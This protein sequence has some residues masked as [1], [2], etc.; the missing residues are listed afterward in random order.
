M[1]TRKSLAD[2]RVAP[3]L[4]DGQIIDEYD[5]GRPSWAQVDMMKP[6]IL[7]FQPAHT[8]QRFTGRPGAQRHVAALLILDT[9]LEDAAANGLHLPV[10][11]FGG[12]VDLFSHHGTARFSAT[13]RRSSPYGMLKGDEP[14][15]GG[16]AMTSE[17]F[18]KGFLKAFVLLADGY[19]K[20]SKGEK[21]FDPYD[22]RYCPRDP[23]H[24]GLHEQMIEDADVNAGR[25]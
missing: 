18:W 17:K 22:E 5:A 2:C 23:A 4:C 20:A 7:V 1:D 19:S 11:R 12:D 13:A 6:V 24:L 8:V 25:K 9:K 3:E 16:T 14:T 21:P 10:Q 15:P